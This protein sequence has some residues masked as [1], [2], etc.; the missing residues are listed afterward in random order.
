MKSSHINFRVLL[1]NMIQSYQS[2]IVIG[3]PLFILVAV[4]ARMSINIDLSY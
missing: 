1:I 4:D 2:Q 3:L